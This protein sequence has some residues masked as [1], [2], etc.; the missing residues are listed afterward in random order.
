MACFLGR[1]APGCRDTARMR[2]AAAAALAVSALAA[3]LQLGT[4][5]ICNSADPESGGLWI[6][7]FGTGGAKVCCS[8]ARSSRALP[9]GARPR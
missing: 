7:A 9:L 6:P 4:A 3:L 5:Q 1:T 2:R 8:L